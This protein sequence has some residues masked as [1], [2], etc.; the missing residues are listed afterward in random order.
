MSDEK[1]DAIQETLAKVL[2]IVAPFGYRDEVDWEMKDQTIN[3]VAMAVRPGITEAGW[4]SRSYLLKPI[5]SDYVYE[6]RRNATGWYLVHV[7]GQVEQAVIIK[8]GSNPH[9]VELSGA[10]LDWLKSLEGFEA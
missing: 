1:L 8:A 7:P 6:L 2:N 9:I 4:A 10:E 5:D 3:G